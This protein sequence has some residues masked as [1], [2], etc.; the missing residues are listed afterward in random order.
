MDGVHHPDCFSGIS[1]RDHP[2]VGVLGHGC[3]EN[4]VDGLKCLNLPYRTRHF[5]KWEHQNNPPGNEK[6]A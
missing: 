6:Q 5:N 2:C 1:L 4:G 3:G